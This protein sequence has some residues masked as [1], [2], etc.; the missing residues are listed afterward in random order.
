MKIAKRKRIFWVF[1]KDCYYVI[2]YEKIES[3]LR[4]LFKVNA[5]HNPDKKNTMSFIDGVYE[6]E[7]CGHHQS[8]GGTL[9]TDKEGNE[10]WG[11][12][13]YPKKDTCSYC[14]MY[15]VDGDER[16]LVPVEDLESLW[17]ERHQR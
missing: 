11:Y 6:C 13:G 17:K 14:N 9:F 16:T 2:K 1:L 8:W 12:G 3:R 4:H 7:R 10:T 15:Y 5:P